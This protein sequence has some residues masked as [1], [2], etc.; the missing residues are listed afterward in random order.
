[1]S[2]CK[3][4]LSNLISSDRVQEAENP[5]KDFSEGLLNMVQHYCHNN[6]DSSWCHHP[7]VKYNHNNN[8]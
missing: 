5:Y 4:A 6:H 2:H 3:T 7:K 1:M 8:K